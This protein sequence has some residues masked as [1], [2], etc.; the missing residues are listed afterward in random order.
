VLADL[1]GL[2]LRLEVAFAPVAVPARDLERHH[3]PVARPDVLDGAAHLLD[4]AHR[5]VPEDVALL[6]EW[7]EDLVEMPVRS[8]DRRRRDADDRVRRLLDRRI[9]HRVDADVALPVPGNGLHGLTFLGARRARPSRAVAC[10]HAHGRGRA[11]NVR[12]RARRRDARVGRLRASRR[13]IASCSEPAGRR[14]RAQIS[15]AARPLGT[16]SDG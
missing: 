3:D 15:R 6:H 8:A 1:G 10:G 4:A 14:E 5:L 11:Q 9:G 7:R 16:V 2:A 12:G 13:E